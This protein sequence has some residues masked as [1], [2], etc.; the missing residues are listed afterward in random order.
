MKSLINNYLLRNFSSAFRIFG[1]FT[2][3][4]LAK[5]ETL[6]ALL[7]ASQ[8]Y[9]PVSVSFKLLNVSEHLKPL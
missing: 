1:S 7:E 6:P 3:N 5:V 8:M 2:T 4:T 9:L